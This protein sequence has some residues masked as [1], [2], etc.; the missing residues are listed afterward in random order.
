MGIKCSIS[1]LKSNKITLCNKWSTIEEAFRYL[2]F[3]E[4]DSK[5]NVLMQQIDVMSRINSNI[6]GDQ[7]YSPEMIVR[8]FEYFSSSRSLSS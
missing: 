8:R 5:T 4:I 6:I 3:M 7:I 2:N 1:S